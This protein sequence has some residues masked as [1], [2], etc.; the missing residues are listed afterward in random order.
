[1]TWEIKLLTSNQ[2]R[3]NFLKYFEKNG[4]KIVPSSSLIPFKDPTLLFSNAGMNQ[5]KDVFIGN[6]T[7][8]YKRAT[9]SQKC[10]RVSGKHNDFKDVGH[11]PR[12]HTFF[13]MLGNF[14][15]GDYFKKDAIHF[16][17][18]LITREFG[19]DPA[20]LWVTV[21]KDDQQAWEIWHKQE[22][23]PAEKIF[24]LGEKDNFW[25]MGDTGPCG[26]C[27]EIHYDFG[28]SPLANHGNCDLTCSCG[29]WVEVWNLVFMQFNRDVNGALTPLP[30][31]S[32]DTGMGFERITA[33]LQGK[34]SNYD[35]DLFLPL[36]A[37]IG[38]IAGTEYGVSVNDD[39]SMRI[40]ADH[41]RAAAFAI[42]DGQYPGNDK[43]G[44]VLRKIMRRAVVHGKKLKIEE[45]FIYRVAGTVIEI[46]K[47]AYP[48]L[49]TLRETVAR[50]IK[51]EEESF[52]D[53]LS[54]GL[55]DF[56][57]RVKRIKASGSQA[58]PGKEAFF[59]YDTRGLP[60]EILEDLAL[61]SGM[62][63]DEEGFVNALKDQQE[64]SRQ[65]YKAGKIR[66]EVAQT[67]FEGKTNFVG[68][69]Y[70]APVTAVLQAIVV[71]GERAETIEQGQKGELILDRTPFY[72]EAGGQVGD[73]GHISMENS[74]AWVVDTLYRGATI[75]HVV[76]MVK[77]SMQVGDRVVAAIN[78]DKRL[79]TMKNH[80]ATH[81][82]QAALQ[83]VLGPHVKQAGSLVAPD[84]LRFDFMHFAP[85]TSAEIQAVE[86]DVNGEIQKNVNV[87]IQQ[88]DLD[89]ALKTGAMALFGEK[90]QDTVR[91]VAVPGYSKE[92]CGGTHVAATG[93]IGLFK[94]IYEG[95]IAAGVRRLE[96]L[97]GPGALNRFRMDEQILDYMQ[98]QYKVTRQEIPAWLEKTHAQIRD[99]QDQMERM[100]LKNAKAGLSSMLERARE[101]HG[102]K[103]VAYTV[104]QTDRA[105]LRAVA[106]E[107]KQ[108]L[109]SGV[110]ILGTPQ[111]DKVALVVM[112]SEDLSGR[113]PAGK[114]IKQVAALVG[115][116][117]G[118]KPQLAEAG[119]KDSAKLADAIER[120]YSIVESILV[121]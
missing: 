84:R 75:S 10:M 28:D 111:D 112:V 42:A 18:E 97:T 60:L 115:G 51:Q 64:R 17:W 106:D 63:I 98:S 108:K 16:S 117:G 57:D 33:I 78:L 19:L 27:S 104:P 66:A 44:Y 109:G 99:L 52:A 93:D 2:I 45:P 6:E 35:T 55:K 21:Y 94:V 86:D 110:V 5:F 31:P 61:E 107:I 87:T 73:T 67:L 9:T 116:T 41:S 121:N 80:T 26:P 48:E 1:M 12:H 102:I 105:S 88:M 24:R 119:G 50:V 96:A 46:M 69:D 7:R 90:Y 13:E 22:G 114:I 43:R 65:D 85:M 83:K 49:V 38:N 14:S 30:A 53:T 91:V 113:I 3:D 71:D 68:Y 8:S 11:S 76:D 54:Q 79:M 62:V 36:L 82:L 58:F 81:L 40:I 25:A 72:A 29:R 103:V 70:Q 56:Y 59:L 101:V 4:H 95:G 32:I 47:G 77:G 92:L 74:S 34:T 120:S 118:G 23:I 39:I 20:R 89:E 100:R 37:E 15:F